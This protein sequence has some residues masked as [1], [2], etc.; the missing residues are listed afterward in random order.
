MVMNCN[1]V[2]A[3]IDIAVEERIPPDSN[4][5]TH[6]LMCEEC[7]NAWDR[8]CEIDEAIVAW[9]CVHP[10]APPFDAVLAALAMSSA[11]QD[12]APRQDL[13]SDFVDADFLNC[14]QPTT[15]ASEVYR[16]RRQSRSS[17]F[18]M[19]MCA[20]CLLLVLG[21]IF[22]QPDISTPLQK[23][24]PVHVAFDR[25]SDAMIAKAPS[26]ITSAVTELVTDVQTLFQEVV[27]ETKTAD[28]EAIREAPNAVVAHLDFEPSDET[29]KS[30]SRAIARG[31]NPLE[32]RL[33]RG[34]GF[35]IQN[36]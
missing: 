12:R 13:A 25:S 34:F 8:Y 7:S 35:L 19:T 9:H 30:Q 16:D 18:A 23:F 11:I 3:A 2:Q 4:V 10:P 6:I 36:F 32:N 24:E 21:S 26:D 15:G 33:K 5:L 22:F 20:S 31:G 29:A 1:E 28:S 17:V 14:I 27:G